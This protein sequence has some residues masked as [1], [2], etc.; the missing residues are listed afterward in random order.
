MLMNKSVNSTIGLIKPRSHDI[1]VLRISGV[2][3]TEDS[4]S[5]M[6][7]DLHEPGSTGID[8]KRRIRDG[9]Q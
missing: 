9:F 3:S 7:S 4:V 2:I 1:E 8:E 6:V 5:H